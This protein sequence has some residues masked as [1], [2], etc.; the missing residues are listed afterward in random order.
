MGAFVSFIIPAYQSGQTLGRTL[1]SIVAQ[2]VRDWE[3]I[4]ANDGSDDRTAVIARD[5]AARDPRIRLLDLAHGGP[6]HARNAG[7][8]ASIGTWLVFLDADDTVLPSFLRHMLARVE[9]EKRAGRGVEVVACGYD[10]VNEAG[11]LSARVPALPL[12][13]DARQVCAS[14]PPGAI[15]SFLV[16]RACIVAADGFDETL[17]TNEDW[18]LWLRVAAGGARFAI[19]RRQLAIY[20]STPNSLSRTGEK[21]LADART[22]I[23]RARALNVAPVPGMEAF[24]QSRHSID[25]ITLRNAFWSAGVSIGQG[26]SALPLVEFVPPGVELWVQKTHLIDKLIDGLVVGESVRLSK[27][28]YRW[29]G[30]REAV[31]E[32]FAAVARH[33]GQP[34]YGFALSG[35]TQSQIARYGRFVGDIDMGQVVAVSATPAILLRGY[36]PS[37]GIDQVIL[38][39]RWLRPAT[40]FSFSAPVF[41]RLSRGDVLRAIQRGVRRRASLHLAEYPAAMAPLARLRRVAAV[42]RRRLNTKRCGPPG[43]HPLSALRRDAAEQSERMHAELARA[44]LPRLATAGAATIHPGTGSG[45]AEWERFFAQEDPWNYGSDYEQ[46]KYRR[47]LGLALTGAPRRAL[48]LACAE[49][50]F[51]ELLAPQVDTLHAVDI[52]P[53][54]IQ[55][56]R[57]R[58]AAFANVTFAQHDLFRGPIV[59]AHDLITCSEVLYFAPSRE[60]LALLARDIG[61]ALVPG[62]HFVHAHGYEIHDDPRRTGFD[63]E[64]TVGAASIHQIF[65]AEPRLALVRAIETELYRIDLFRRIEP[66]EARPDPVIE[67]MP[68]GAELEPEVAASVVW[69]GAL[70]TRAAARAERVYRLPVLLYGAHVPIGQLEQQLL[71]LRRRGFHSVTPEELHDGA[72][73]AGSLRGRPVL[74][75]AD[76]VGDRWVDTAWPAIRQNGFGLHL[77]VGTGEGVDWTRLIALA[78]EGVTFGSRLVSDNPADNVPG[79]DLLAEAVRSRLTLEHV[80]G[81]AVRTVAPPLGLSDTRVEQV[82][83]AAGYNRLFLAD[84]GIAPVCGLEMQTPRVPVGGGWTLDG[85]ARLFGPDIPPPDEGDR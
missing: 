66:G 21:M 18:D 57:R 61:T 84:G 75:T 49:G 48:E 71:F 36:V 31:E 60:R 30:V 70:C 72:T 29:A 46:L 38:R 52:S 56:A 22:V 58:T 17:T 19:V 40:M 50:R 82:L 8:A 53:T 79:A 80:L 15:H 74:L 16:R 2:T 32:F 11:E 54:A 41:G 43:F 85:F 25:D 4:V 62:G 78:G 65:A 9:Q 26:R 28:V 69:N 51:T 13:R 24:D 73:R 45:A 10:R 12:D 35:L 1:S 63:W 27:L 42:A 34:D 44:G 67:R 23:A 64:D 59:G 55:R 76:D 5:W 47:T 37:A 3:A 81:A 7:I 77:S 83:A 68:V 6:S 20:W 14:G 33:T 39:L